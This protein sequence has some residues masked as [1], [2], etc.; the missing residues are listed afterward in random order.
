MLNHKSIV[1][2]LS[3]TG[4]KSKKTWK[5]SVWQNY[6]FAALE[7]L[8]PRQYY[9]I[10]PE[11]KEYR[12]A[13]GFVDFMI[14]SKDGH[15]NGAV[16]WLVT[17]CRK[18][19]P[20]SKGVAEYIKEH[21]YRFVKDPSGQYP[22]KYKDLEQNFVVLNVSHQ[23]SEVEIPG[24]ISCTFLELVVNDD[25]NDI[26]LYIDDHEISIEMGKPFI[27]DIQNRVKLSPS[28]DLPEG[29]LVNTIL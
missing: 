9:R 4:Q 23:R 13:R 28:I 22:Q 20:A 5:E 24:V 1:N 27:Y 7:W 10:D 16:E 2:C 29:I 19:T 18:G 15:F 12:D 25:L 6:F 21:Y 14:S 11:F 17:E 3:T 26:K 8:L